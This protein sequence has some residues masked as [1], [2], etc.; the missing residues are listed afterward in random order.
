MQRVNFRITVDLGPDADDQQRSDAAAA[1]RKILV[2]KQ[3]GTVVRERTASAAE[4]AKSADL[5]GDAALVA[6]VATST[7]AILREAIRAWERQRTG[8]TAKVTLGDHSLE[9][10]GITQEQAK[11]IAEGFWKQASAP[12]DAG[13]GRP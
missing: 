12:E 11:Q 3:V 2:A 13:D 10:N 1:L 9:L 4:G 6:T 5:L 7:F 8:R